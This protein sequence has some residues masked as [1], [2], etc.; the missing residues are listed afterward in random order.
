M[1]ARRELVTPRRAYQPETA[2]D[3]LGRRKRA[4]AVSWRCHGDVMWDGETILTL[5]QPR[6][7]GSDGWRV[8]ML[9]WRG[10]GGT[11]GAAVCWA[12]AAANS[13]VMG[14]DTP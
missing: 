1:M 6:P 9:S 13:R 7:H 2:L 14:Q 12:W 10:A 8:P 11:G 3:V 5:Y 4:A